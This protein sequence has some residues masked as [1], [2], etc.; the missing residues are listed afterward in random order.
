MRNST[1]ARW[2]CNLLKWREMDSINLHGHG[3]SADV[4]GAAQDIV[5]LLHSLSEFSVNNVHNVDETRFLYKL[6][7]KFLYVL[8]QENKKT[9]RVVKSM[10]SKDCITLYACT[11]TSVAD[12]V[13]RA[14][15]GITKN[16]RAFRLESCPV[17]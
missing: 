7:Q 10:E 12:K 13:S 1:V 4:T 9:L 14:I 17:T 15:I 8:K 16:P 2:A 3:A 11:K 6:L 5:K